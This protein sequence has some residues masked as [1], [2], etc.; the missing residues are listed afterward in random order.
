MSYRPVSILVYR[1]LNNRIDVN[2]KL[3]KQQL[4]DQ[5]IEVETRTLE[6][7]F[8]NKAT[9]ITYFVDDRRVLPGTNLQAQKTDQT[10]GNTGNIFE[11]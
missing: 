5:N 1:K 3:H 6:V 7:D 4:R 8:P 9:K 2:H 11:T 10:L